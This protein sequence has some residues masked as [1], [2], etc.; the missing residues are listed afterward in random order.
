MNKNDLIVVCGAGGFIAGHLVKRLR[1][2]GFTKIRAVDIKPINEWFQLFEDVENISADLRLRE[3]CFE[4]LTDARYVFNLACDMG[5]MGFIETNRT[6]CM[7]SI[8]INTHLLLAAK[9]FKVDRFLFTSSACV[10]NTDLQ[11]TSD[12]IPLTEDMAYPALA[13]N[14]YGWEKLLSE[15]MCQHFEEDFGLP[16]RMV[17]LHNVYG[18]HGSFEGGREKAPA[19]IARK[20]AMA[21][22]TGKH[23]IEIW[24]DGSQTRTFLYVDDCIRGLIDVMNSEI[25]YPINL[26]S[27]ELVSINHLVDIV[28]KIAGVKLTKSYVLDAPQGVR[29][30]N[31]DSS[32]VFE[33]IGWA[34]EYTLE[35]GMG[36]TYQWIEE[37]LSPRFSGMGTAV[38]VVADSEGEEEQL[39]SN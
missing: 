7:I 21:K 1:E 36:L 28:S 5:G 14:G 29:G 13:E 39:G 37:E 31:C 35:K 15:R 12:A 24:G 2:Q 27:S 32:M 20:I 38:P 34:P 18:P 30:R 3:R 16:T 11:K 10:Y 33:E 8:L 4:A 23:E 6:A 22:L 9:E 19:A 25:N 26:G 17:R